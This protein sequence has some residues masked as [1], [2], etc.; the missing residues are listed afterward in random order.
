MLA[1]ASDD[2][3]VK[4]WKLYGTLLRT[5]SGHSA[6]VNRVAFSP[7]GKALASA[8]EDKTLKLWQLD[9]TIL[10]TLSGHTA[11]VNG[12]IFSPDGKAVSAA[13]P[14]GLIASASEDKT[15]I[16]WN[17]DRVLNLDELLV[18]GC[19]WVRDYLKTNPDVSKSDAYGAK[20]SAGRHLCDRVSSGAKGDRI[21]NQGK[22]ASF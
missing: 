14:K 13:M 15:V 1:S 20:E 22:K 21:G 17:L 19:N 11:G 2:D 8:S 3:T 12:V 4:L 5:F 16:L 10:A 9:G 18:Y 6:G 7:D